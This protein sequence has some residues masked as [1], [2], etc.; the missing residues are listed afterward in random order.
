MTALLAERYQAFALA[1]HG[2]RRE[3]SGIPKIPRGRSVMFCLPLSSLFNVFDSALP[4]GLCMADD[5]V[6]PFRPPPPLEESVSPEERARRLKDEVKRLARLSR[7]EWVY[8]LGLP[9]YAEKY[10]VDKDAFTELVE[11]EVSE[12]EKK[13][14]EEKAEERRREQ[15]AERER[16]NARKEQE[17][18]Q[19]EQRRAQKEADKEA[20]KRQR[21][22][23]EELA[24]ILKLP[25]VEHEPRLA[26]L[27][28]RSGDDLRFL[29]DEFAK[30]VDDETPSGDTGYVE[31]WPEPAN[32]HELLEETMT[33]LRRFIVIPD[34][35]TA[36]AIAIVLWIAFAWL[37]EIAEKSPRLKITSPKA[38]NAKTR[39]CNWISLLTPRARIIDNPTG[40]SIY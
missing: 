11:A 25:S 17:R 2:E 26:A 20:E 6:V 33:Q 13:R 4:E 7:S 1:M 40:P 30:L 14:R 8:Y 36:V 12:A 21:E 23:E 39:A 10:G 32:T 34:D 35:D 3:I 24:A 16:T 27:A 18:Q 15:R 22:R 37:I 29:L 38:G 9:G 5:T 31:P 19:R 28:E